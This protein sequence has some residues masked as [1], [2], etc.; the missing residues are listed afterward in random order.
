MPAVALTDSAKPGS[1]ARRGSTRSRTQTAAHSAGTAARDR[2]DARASS[3][4]APMAAARTTLGLGRARIT[5]PISARTATAACTR[6]STARRRRGRRTPAR[7]IATFAPD[8]AVRCASPARRKSSSSTGSMAVV[9][10]TTRPGSS[11]AGAGSSTRRADSRSASRSPPA[12]ACST[13]G[14]PTGVGDPRAESTATSCSPGRGGET[15]TRTWTCCPGRSRR[16]SAAGPNRTTGSRMR[17]VVSRSVRRS[18]VASRTARGAPPPGTTCESP[19]SSSTTETVRPPSATALSGDSSRA[20][21]RTAAVPA[22]TA[23]PASRARTR[24]VL[25][26]RPR[27]MTPARTHV[28]RPVQPSVDGA[29]RGA[30]SV[31]P[32]TPAAAGTSRASSQL[33]RTARPLTPSPVPP[34]PPR[35]PGRCRARRRAAPRSGTGPPARGGR[36]C[37]GR[38]PAR[39]PA[40]RPARPPRR[41]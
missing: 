40:G 18:A 32:H 9:S 24:A 25:A 39:C 21:L 28:A 30:T 20:A 33:H 27:A 4:T 16:Q 13:P 19:S 5:N 6:R 2:P 35:S 22:V 37:A 1:A 36:R 12:V 11:P 7:T 41:D 14:R 8:T 15:S 31:V 10:P 34:V 17:Y 26:L 38:A 23:T 3:V 29:A